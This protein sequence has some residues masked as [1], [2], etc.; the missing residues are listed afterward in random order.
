MIAYIKGHITKR[1]PTYVYL[2]CNDLAYY[3]NITLF[4]YSAIEQSDKVQLCR[5]GELAHQISCEAGGECV[6]YTRAEGVFDV[7]PARPWK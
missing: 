3:V 1:T 6:I 4:T 5:Y 2:E 7:I